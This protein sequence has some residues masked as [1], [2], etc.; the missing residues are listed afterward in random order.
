MTPQ[1]IIDL[2]KV[3]YPKHMRQM[4]GCKD[5]EDIT[6]YCEVENESDLLVLGEPGKW[7]CLVARQNNEVE[8]VDIAAHRSI[9][10]M[11]QILRKVK[12]FAG[13]LPVYCDARD[14]TSFKLLQRLSRRG[15]FTLQIQST[16]RWE[17]ETMHLVR[18]TF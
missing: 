4:Q 7:Y 6:D 18:I 14:S 17:K 2:E 16:Y 3:C 11:F 8:F 9:P 15:S 1:A 5:W 12:D 10:P 13:G